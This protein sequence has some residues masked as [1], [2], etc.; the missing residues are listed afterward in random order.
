M[1][2]AESLGI[3][4][5]VASIIGLAVTAY[6]AW[7]IRKLRRRYIRQVMLKTCLGKLQAHQKNLSSKTTQKNAVAIRQ[8]LSRTRTVLERVALHT[9]KGSTIKWDISE[10]EEVLELSDDEIRSRV[11][12]VTP[13]LDER[14]ERLEL[15]LTELE[16]GDDDG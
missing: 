7:A 11:G 10:I 8:Q 1:T 14:I 9:Q 12:D 16:W 6:V 4:G 13:V 15:D 2:F 3:A 5:S